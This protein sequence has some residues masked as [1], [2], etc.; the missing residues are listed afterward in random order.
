MA[1][2]LQ[3]HLSSLRPFKNTAFSTWSQ[4]GGARR[5]SCPVMSQLSAWLSVDFS[6]E[7][8]LV[9]QQQLSD[10]GC[11]QGVVPDQRVWPDTCA[12]ALS[13]RQRVDPKACLRL[14]VDVLWLSGAMTAWMK[15]N[16]VD[17]LDFLGVLG[18]ISIGHYDSNF[19]AKQTV[20]CDPQSSCSW[21]ISL[22]FSFLKYTTWSSFREIFRSGRR[23]NSEDSLK[24]G[25]FERNMSDDC[26]Y[27]NL[28]MFSVW[29]WH[30]NR[31]SYMLICRDNKCYKCMMWVIRKS[32]NY[33]G[34]MGY[35]SCRLEAGCIS[36]TICKLN[37][38]YFGG[39]VVKELD[40]H[41]VKTWHGRC[42]RFI[43]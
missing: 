25:W 2:D 10:G 32:V 34:G 28:L 39:P 40:S 15:L 38:W 3:L 6:H 8:R 1:C 22:L 4:S 33:R 19:T 5:H 42:G 21:V 12:A 9:R 14:L 41:N 30:L 7:H 24:Q 13:H 37:T 43:L 16:G 23:I 36:K 18:R 26:H 31:S 27:G 20:I 17:D 35:K 29:S 11:W